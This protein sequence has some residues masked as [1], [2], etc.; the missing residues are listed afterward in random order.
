MGN[1]LAYVQESV[2]ILEVRGSVKYK[3]YA[4]IPRFELAGTTADWA[5]A[6]FEELNLAKMVGA[7]IRINA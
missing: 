4:L 5:G 1:S 2:K 3:D 6:V 7:A